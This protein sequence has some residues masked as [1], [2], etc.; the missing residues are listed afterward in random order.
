MVGK[1]HYR[2]RLYIDNPVLLRC[3]FVKTFRATVDDSR[4]LGR[5]L[6]NAAFLVTVIEQQRYIVRKTQ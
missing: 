6:S 5:V 1:S 3:V 4:Q 2:A